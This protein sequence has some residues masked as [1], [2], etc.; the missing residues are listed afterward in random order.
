MRPLK[1]EK[2]GWFTTTFDFSLTEFDR[3]NIPSAY[4][5]LS[6]RCGADEV[7]FKDLENGT[8]KTKAGYRKLQF[9]G[10]QAARDGLLDFWIDTCCI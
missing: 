3:H 9:C 10:D 8:G 1:R 4:A 2:S 5:L 7:T 6:H